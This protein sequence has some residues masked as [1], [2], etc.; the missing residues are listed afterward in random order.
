MCCS[1]DVTCDE[2]SAI[3]RYVIP[4]D[5]SWSYSDQI[6]EINETP[7]FYH[8][9]VC[10]DVVFYFLLITTEFIVFDGSTFRHHVTDAA[11]Y[12]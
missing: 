6:P 4:S 9:V 5:C 11:C 7:T 2:V 12:Y 8:K 3:I 1:L 10:Q